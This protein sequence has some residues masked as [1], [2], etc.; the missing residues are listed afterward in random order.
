M[1]LDESCQ[2]IATVIFKLA[3]HCCDQREA[4]LMPIQC[5]LGKPSRKGW[6]HM[7]CRSGKILR[8]CDRHPSSPGAP[9]L[10]EPAFPGSARSSGVGMSAAGTHGI[11]PPAIPARLAG[12]FS[13]PVL[14]P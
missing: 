8:R 1:R 2:R 13:R 3:S 12:A 4:C 7:S 10:H 14:A 6:K 11:Q 5:C 9:G